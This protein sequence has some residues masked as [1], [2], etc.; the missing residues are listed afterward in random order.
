M[1]AQEDYMLLD[2]D[3]FEKLKGLIYMISKH[4]ERRN[5]EIRIALPEC[6]ITL[7]FCQDT[8]PIGNNW[9]MIF[10]QGRKIF[11]LDV[12]RPKVDIATVEYIKSVGNTGTIVE[13]LNSPVT[14]TPE[15]QRKFLN[16]LANLFIVPD[17]GSTKKA[18]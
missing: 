4:Y 7:V 11:S 13:P 15:E 1:S 5:R 18:I 17:L 16:I 14:F 8:E 6:N 9:V 2:L 10:Y 12:T 3:I